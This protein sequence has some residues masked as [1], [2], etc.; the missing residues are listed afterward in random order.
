M[1]SAL[2]LKHLVKPLGWLILTIITGSSFT[3]SQQVAPQT[4]ENCTLL[5]ALKSPNSEH[6]EITIKNDIAQIYHVIKYPSDSRGFRPYDTRRYEY[7]IIEGDKMTFLTGNHNFDNLA[8]MKKEEINGL[9]SYEWIIHNNGQFYIIKKDN[10]AYLCR[11]L[12]KQKVNDL[13]YCGLVKVEINHKIG[14]KNKDGV[15]VI[16]AIYDDAHN[17]SEGFTSVKKESLWGLIDTIGNI[18]IPFEYSWMGHFGCGV[19]PVSETTDWIDSY[20]VDKK[21]KRVFDRK[22]YGATGFTDE[23]VALVRILKPKT[24]EYQEYRYTFIDSL[25][26]EIVNEYYDECE[27]SLV[28]GMIV[29]EKNRKFGCI[30]INGKE[31]IPPVYDRILSGEGNIIARRNGKYGY[32]DKNN[33]EILPFVY[34]YLSVEKNKISFELNGKYGVMTLE[35]DIIIEPIYDDVWLGETFCAIKKQTSRQNEYIWGIVDYS[36]KMTVTPK[37]TY[38]LLSGNYARVLNSE[39]YCYIRCS[40]GKYYADYNGFYEAPSSFVNTVCK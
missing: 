40:D 2:L 17:F 30:D 16:P 15:M 4:W 34:D 9:K 33:N 14:F 10:N 35:G 11:E 23:K 22:Y 1:E 37:Y 3:Y 31:R 26:H 21:N 6:Y 7:A 8:K 19:V 39:G 32:I 12:K 13:Y 38:L 18:I 36:G 24:G 25:G 27:C 20:F 29:V 28:E 5:P